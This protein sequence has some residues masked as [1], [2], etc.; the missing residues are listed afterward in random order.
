MQKDRPYKKILH[1]CCRI[2]WYNHP[3]GKIRLRMKDPSG[4]RDFYPRCRAIAVLVWNLWREHMPPAGERRPVT[5]KVM[6]ALKVWELDCPVS[7]RDDAIL[8]V[9]IVHSA[10]IA[11]GLNSEINHNTLAKKAYEIGKTL[12]IT[13]E[14]VDWAIEQSHTNLLKWCKL[15][16]PK[17]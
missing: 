6:D 11:V 14:Q 9:G 10:L 17:G 2:E 15:L 7:N 13:E 3:N 5:Q 4:D 1:N 12:N 16:P 8:V